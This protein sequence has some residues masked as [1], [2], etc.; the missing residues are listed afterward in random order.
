M[1]LHTGVHA[2]D[3]LE[4]PDLD[5]ELPAFMGESRAQLMRSQ[6]LMRGQLAA[7]VLLLCSPVVPLTASSDSIAT[8]GRV[9][10]ILLLAVLRDTTAHG[11]NSR[12]LTGR[13][14]GRGCCL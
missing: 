1:L 4:E 11:H 13:C 12:S 8:I 2:D 10:T 14:H 3:E 5:M 7:E 6:E 9:N